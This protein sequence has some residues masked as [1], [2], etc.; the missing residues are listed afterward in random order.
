MSSPSGGIA[1]F[2]SKGSKCSSTGTSPPRRPSAIS[3]ELRPTAHQGQATSEMKLIF[4]SFGKF[5]RV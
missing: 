3:S 2:S 5:D 4:M 1:G